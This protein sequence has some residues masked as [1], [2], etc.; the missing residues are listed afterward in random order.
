MSVLGKQPKLKPDTSD[1]LNHSS[2]RLRSAFFTNS[3]AASNPF[4]FFH[5]RA[6]AICRSHASVPRDG[7]PS[8]PSNENSDGDTGLSCSFADLSLSSDERLPNVLASPFWAHY[9]LVRIG[10]QNF[11]KSLQYT[12]HKVWIDFNYSTL[13]DGF[14]TRLTLVVWSK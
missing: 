2:A 12:L 1:V 5:L 4:Q 7:C 8:M 3:R 14:K 9:W 13:H 6:E 11:G 10:S